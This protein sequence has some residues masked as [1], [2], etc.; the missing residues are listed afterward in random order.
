MKSDG[1]PLTGLPIC[2]IIY[3]YLAYSYHD[4]HSLGRR[5]TRSWFETWP[6]HR[7]FV[8]AYGACYN[9]V[10]IWMSFVAFHIVYGGM[11]RVCRMLLASRALE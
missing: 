2:A 1:P 4:A 7:A 6:M 11:F 5:S 3:L 8:T 9:K 10:Y